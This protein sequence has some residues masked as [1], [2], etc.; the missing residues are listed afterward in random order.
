MSEPSPHPASAALAQI[1]MKGRSWRN[2]TTVCTA[3][4]LPRISG[5]YWPLSSAFCFWVSAWPT[6]S[7][8]LIGTTLPA[9]VDAG[10]GRCVGDPH[11]ELALGRAAVRGHRLRLALQ[12]RGDAVVDR[13]GAGP[14]RRHVPDDLAR[15]VRI[16]RPEAEGVGLGGDRAGGGGLA[17]Q[18]RVA[19]LEDPDGAEGDCEP[20]LVHPHREGALRGGQ[21]LG[22]RRALGRGGA[23]VRRRGLLRRRV[24]VREDGDREIGDLLVTGVAHRQGQVGVLGQALLAREV[25]VDDL[26]RELA[27]G[28]VGVLAVTT[29]ARCD[30]DGQERGYESDSEAVPGLRGTGC[31]GALLQRR[32]QHTTHP[33][34]PRLAISRH[35]HPATVGGGGWGPH[36][37]GFLCV[38]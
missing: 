9:L 28:F 26:H 30:S 3:A 35:S 20:L 15:C 21:L 32:G 11:D 25:G 16:E 19:L 18:L 4:G 24:G 36:Q 5:G 12:A 2:I 10:L 31:R 22:G 13:V 1:A 29:A 34:R 17:R 6:M 7:S 27:L 33:T 14:D 8:G 37:I 23:L 38:A